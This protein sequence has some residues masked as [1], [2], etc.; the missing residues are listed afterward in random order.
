VR[1]IMEIV[2]SNFGHVGLIIIY[3]Q[4][5]NSEFF[6][7]N[8]KRTISRINGVVNR[9]Q[10]WHMFWYCFVL[11]RRLS[12]RFRIDLVGQKINSDVYGRVFI[13]SIYPRTFSKGNLQ[14][15]I[16]ILVA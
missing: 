8:V 3:G 15:V 2:E 10:V 9:S 6:V 11:H 4:G 12:K 14:A 16:P 7:V 5:T 13:F 1:K